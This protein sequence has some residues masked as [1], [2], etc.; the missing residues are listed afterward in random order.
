MSSPILCFVGKTV[1]VQHRA[2]LRGADSRARRCT[3]DTNGTAL[4]WC[5]PPNCHC[6]G[7][8]R[9]WQS[10]EG[11][12]DIHRVPPNAIAIK[13]DCSGAHCAAVGGS[14]A[15]W[16]RSER[17]YRRN[18]CTPFFDTRCKLPVLLREGHAAPLQWLVQSLH[19][20][21]Q[22][23]GRGS[24]PAAAAAVTLSSP[25]QTECTASSGS[26]CNQNHG[27]RTWETSSCEFV[28]RELGR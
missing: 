18:W 10:R 23:S 4:K 16:M 5:R 15:L 24:P 26:R 3:C 8:L 21:E 11:T 12:T 9:P 2:F 20:S 25:C 1:Q 19:C 22:K 13:S 17:R 14:A 28:S 6:E 7:A 27:S